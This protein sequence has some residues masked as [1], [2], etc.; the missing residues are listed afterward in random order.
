MKLKVTK[1]GADRFAAL[2][3]LDVNY[4]TTDNTQ[5]LPKNM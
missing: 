1:L 3:S 5:A 2:E 4:D